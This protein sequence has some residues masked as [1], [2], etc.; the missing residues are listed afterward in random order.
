MGKIPESMRQLR[1]DSEPFM[2]LCKNCKHV[3]YN[4]QKKDHRDPSRTRPTGEFGECTIC[5]SEGK[6][7]KKFIPE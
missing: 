7:C 6:T 5:K 3:G 1:K 4:H 2:K